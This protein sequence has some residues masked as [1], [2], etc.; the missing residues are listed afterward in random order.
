M[1]CMRYIV[2]LSDCQYGCVPL[3]R[4]TA[5]DWGQGLWELAMTAPDSWDSGAHPALLQLNGH[6]EKDWLP[7]SPYP[8]PAAPAAVSMVCPGMWQLNQLPL[9][10]SN[11]CT[12]P[13]VNPFTVPCH[14]TEPNTKHDQASVSVIQ[15]AYY[16]ET[17][18]TAPKPHA[19]L[20]S[21]TVLWPGNILLPHCK[22]KQHH[23]HK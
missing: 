1:S 8:A 4:R 23:G 3:V 20:C 10:P 15:L 17:R 21:T 16:N 22:T 14:T 13:H 6:I 5:E 9:H 2:C 11:P 7:W 12:G 18:L 19:I